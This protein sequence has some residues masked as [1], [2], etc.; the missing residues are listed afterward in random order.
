MNLAKSTY[1]NRVFDRDRMALL[2]NV[3]L[4][5]DCDEEAVLSFDRCAS[6]P[7]E[8]PTKKDRPRPRRHPCEDFDLD[9]GDDL[10]A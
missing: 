7:F 1:D 3:L 2:A 10:L 4:D 8:N 9:L 6:L 5:A